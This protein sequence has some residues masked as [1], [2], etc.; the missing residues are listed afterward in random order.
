[1][2]CW[3]KIPYQICCHCLHHL[4]L[5]L[6]YFLLGLGLRTKCYHVQICQSIKSHSACFCRK[7]VQTIFLVF[8]NWFFSFFDSAS[9]VM[10]RHVCFKKTWKNV[11]KK[12]KKCYK[13]KKKNMCNV[14][15]LCNA[16]SK[17]CQIFTFWKL[18]FF[19]CT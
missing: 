2:N 10:N 7:T 1:M 19:H 18:F 9:S 11:P 4:F 3:T 13:K 6:S 8:I 16:G 15:V 14:H 17:I 12:M 5:F